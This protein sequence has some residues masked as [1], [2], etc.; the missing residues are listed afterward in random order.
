MT[1]TPFIAIWAAMALAVLILAAWRQ[2]IDFHEDD[3]I[4]L[5]EQQSGMVNDQV[6]L[7]RKVG[8]IDRW[9]KVLTVATIAYGVGIACY[10]LYQQWIDSSRL[11]GS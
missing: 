8:V 1:M 5:G 6:T 3:S 10:Y 7:A 11:P 9:G 4:H 2:F